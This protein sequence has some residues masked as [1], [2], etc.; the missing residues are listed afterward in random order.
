MVVHPFRDCTNHPIKRL[1]RH[2]LTKVLRLFRGILQELLVVV[3][4][5]LFLYYLRSRYIR[6]N[7]A[8]GFQINPAWQQ[9][10][11]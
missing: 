9:V 11:T 8:R 10:H 5:L 1:I 3:V 4:C 6:I 2:L 7:S